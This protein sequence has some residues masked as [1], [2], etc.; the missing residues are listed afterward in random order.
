VAIQKRWVLT[1]WCLEAVLERWWVDCPSPPLRIANIGRT[2]ELQWLISVLP[3][4]LL[5]PVGDP[6]LAGLITCS[7]TKLVHNRAV[8]TDQKDLRH[9]NETNDCSK[10][11]VSIMPPWWVSD[12]K[13][14]S[15]KKWFLLSTSLKLICM[16]CFAVALKEIT[17]LRVF[18]SDK[19]S[20]LV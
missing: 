7:W 18:V 3:H 11:D 20:S 14:H 15:T 9:A 19:W 12:S 6:D 4:A 8:T 13:E 1:G 17:A 10:T 16:W 2:F 5:A